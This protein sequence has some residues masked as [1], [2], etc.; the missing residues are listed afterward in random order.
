MLGLHFES[1]F[2]NFDNNISNTKNVENN[3]IN[4]TNIPTKVLN[5]TNGDTNTINFSNKRKK[6]QDQ[7][8]AYNPPQANR[9]D[10]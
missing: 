2:I 4:V 7:C 5:D 1:H 3:S 8:S 9:L 10:I 6:C